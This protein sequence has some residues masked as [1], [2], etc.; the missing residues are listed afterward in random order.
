MSP[1]GPRAAEVGALGRRQP[2][3]VED[4]PGRARADRADADQRDVRGPGAGHDVP[5]RRL[6][7]QGGARGRA[8]QQRRGVQVAVGAAQAA[9]QLAHELVGGGEREVRRQP[10]HQRHDLQPA[11]LV[12]RGGRHDGLQRPPPRQ[13]EHLAVAQRVV[14][15]LGREPARVR[16]RVLVRAERRHPHVGQPEPLRE[17]LLEVAV[18][19]PLVLD[20]DLDDPGGARA[21]EQA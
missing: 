5:D 18:A 17:R 16:P 19:T 12:D 15:P 13:R 2:E 11:R 9:G 4:P 6:G 8:P 20:A 14:E 10:A 21:A 3:G 1:T 7:E